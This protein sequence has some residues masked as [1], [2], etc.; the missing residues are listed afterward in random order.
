MLWPLALVLACSDS[1]GPGDDDVASAC[2]PHHP[3][4]ERGQPAA[5]QSGGE[6]LRGAR[7]TT[8]RCGSSSRTRTSPGEAGRRVPALRGRCRRAAR[9]SRWYA[10]RR[11]RF[12]ADHRAGGGSRPAPVRVRAR[13]PHLQPVAS[14][15]SS[16]FTTTRPTTTWTKTA[17]SIST[18]TRSS[19]PSASGA[20]KSDGDPFERL[21]SLLIDDLE[22]IDA[23]LEG[24]SRYALAY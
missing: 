8:A 2:R 22:E 7:A 19:S 5:L 4:A 12:G 15:P 18:T 13:G 9:L 17:T 20:R 24:F 23:E 16:R 10:V 6:L 21:G 11:G 14:R 3:P 1:G